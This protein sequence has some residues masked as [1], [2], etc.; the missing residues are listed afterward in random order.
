VLHEHEDKKEAL[1]RDLGED[2]IPIAQ[3]LVKLAKE[4]KADFFL[5]VSAPHL[6]TS[7]QARQIQRLSTV[8]RLEA[9]LHALRSDTSSW[10]NAGLTAEDES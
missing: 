8:E 2:I 3:A 4:Y 9:E 7:H 1:K 6:G 10:L 5:L